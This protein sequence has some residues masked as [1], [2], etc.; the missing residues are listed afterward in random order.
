MGLDM[1]LTKEVSVKRWKHLPKKDQFTVNVKK[2]DKE[3]K[4]IIAEN[5]SV[6]TEDVGYWR[7]ANAIHAWF[8]KNCGNNED[9]CQKMYISVN[10]LKNLLNIV[11]QILS[12]TKLIDGKDGKVLKNPSLAKKLLPTTEGFFFGSTNYDEYYWQDLIDTKEIITKL[13]ND[14]DGFEDSVDIYYQA[15][16]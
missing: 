9:N 12:S 5:V 1:Y 6:I 16:W 8:V 3:Y 10:D 15:S 2:G 13:L 4:G 14:I 7:K 11:E